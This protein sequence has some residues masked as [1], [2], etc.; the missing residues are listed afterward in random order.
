LASGSW[1]SKIKIWDTV[2]GI[3]LKTLTGHS[4]PVYSLAVLSDGSLA[5]GSYK[6]IIIWD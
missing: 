3:E 1:D 6:T 5:R 2:K 4:N